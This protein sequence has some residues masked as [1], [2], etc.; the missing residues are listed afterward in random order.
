MA[1][2]I[3]NAVRVKRGKPFALMVL[4]ALS[5]IAMLVIYLLT[6]TSTFNPVLSRKVLALMGICIAAGLLLSAVEIKNGKYV[7]YL[8]GL[9]MWLEFL[10]SQ[11]SY[12]SN[13]L[14]GIDGNQFSIGF[15]MTTVTGLLSWC[16]VLI[17]AIIQKKEIETGRKDA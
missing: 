8:L 7:L 11:S 13:V 12:I 9:W 3:L 15:L 16:C 10:V 14:V 5:F 6:G 4:A 17:S 1:G 2:T